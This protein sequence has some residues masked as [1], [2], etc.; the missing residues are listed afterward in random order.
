MWTPDTGLDPASASSGPVAG[1]D[2]LRVAGLPAGR[3]P[4]LY[5]LCEG[6]SAVW[7]L[8]TSA[9]VVERAEVERPQRQPASS[10]QGL[11]PWPWCDGV[12]VRR[13][14]QKP[15]RRRGGD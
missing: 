15:R 7:R 5:R 14:A 2:H 8:A 13:G 6:V 11:Q 10:P 9:G 12:I 4:V 1:R 3:G